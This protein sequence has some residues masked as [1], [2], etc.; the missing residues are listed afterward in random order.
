MNVHMATIAVN[1]AIVFVM[2]N[3]GEPVVSL[4]RKAAYANNVSV[5]LAYTSR[6]LLTVD[7][8][9]ILDSLNVLIQEAFGYAFV[10]VDAAVA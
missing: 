1:P 4:F 2:L 9:T 10:G 8:E 7:K 5:Q 6:C 3:T